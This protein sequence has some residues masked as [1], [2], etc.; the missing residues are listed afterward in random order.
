M[1][2][3]VATRQKADTPAELLRWYN[4]HVNLLL[5]FDGLKTATLYCRSGATQ[6]APEY[7]CLYRFASAAVF[8]DFEAS[9]AKERAR[10]V[11]PSG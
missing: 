2:N 1:I 4:D 10:Q 6:A 7:L 9:D 3:V 11:T 5:R 8:A